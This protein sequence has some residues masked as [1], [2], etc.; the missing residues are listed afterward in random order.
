MRLHSRCK[1]SALAHISVCLWLVLCGQAAELPMVSTPL[2]PVTNAYHGTT[3]VDN[4]QWL[5][6]ASVPD[7]RQWTREQN[8]RTQ[9]YLSRLPYREGIAQQLLQ[10]RSDESARF[11][12]LE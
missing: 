3:V 1:T 12:S 11:S 5:E 10:F 4:Y 2:R 6:D 7:V 9:A 8:E